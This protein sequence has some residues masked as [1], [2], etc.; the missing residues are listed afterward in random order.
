MTG[1]AA[2]IA[3][4]DPNRYNSRYRDLSPHEMTQNRY[5]S[6]YKD[7][8]PHEMTKISIEF[9]VD[10]GILVISCDDC[11]RSMWAELLVHR[12]YDKEK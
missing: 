1:G 9:V 6:R 2:I 11:Y 12:M 8:S 4:N 10:I 7:L 5:N 3:R